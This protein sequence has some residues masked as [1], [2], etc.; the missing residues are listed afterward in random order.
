MLRALSG[1]I[2]P[3][4]MEASAQ[5]F[6][7]SPHFAV[8]GA[9]QDKSKFGYR[10]FAW[11]HQHSLSVTPIN[12]GR[13]SISLPAKVYDTVPSVGALTHPEQT[14]LSFLT[15]P[16]TTRKVLEEAKKAGVRAVWLQPGSFEDPDLE[17]AKEN[18]ES[19][20]GGFEEG[21]MG[22]EGW[23]VLVDGENALRAAGRKIVK[24]KL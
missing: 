9:S 8:V 10:I 21:T 6:F 5:R 4:A 18:F 3:A 15:P 12:P 20:V 16:S 13:P 24:Q 22:G 23:C 2:T 7:S 19:A 17:F 11:Y 1:N 14:A